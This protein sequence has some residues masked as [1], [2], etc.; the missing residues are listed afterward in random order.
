M[1]NP[2]RP[3]FY[4][5]LYIVILYLR[6]QEYVPALLNLPIVPIS[7]L[8]ATFFWFVGQKKDFQA[9]Q[10]TLLLWLTIGMSISVVRSDGIKSA[11]TVIYDFIPTLLLF[12]IVATSVDGVKRFKQLSWVLMLIS[13]VI[14]MH[15]IGQAGDEEGLGWTGAKMIEGR[16]T[17]LG[18]LNDP[19][20]L[21]MAFLMSLPFLFYLAHQSSSFFIRMGCYGITGTMLYAIYLC[22][23][24]GSILSLLAMAS[25]YAIRRFGWLR[26]ALVGPLLSVPI[27]LFAPSRMSDVSADEESAAGRVDAWFEGF[28]MFKN[29]PIFG[30]GKGLFVDHNELT[31]HN[32][33][34]LAIAELGLFGYFFWISVLFI[35]GLML[36]RILNTPAP[37]EPAVISPKKPTTPLAWAD[38]QLMSATLMYALIGSLVAAFFLSRSY[39]VFLYLLVGLI[40]AMYQLARQHWPQFTEIRARSMLGKLLGV[41]IG[42]IVLLW[43]IT[44]IL[45]KMS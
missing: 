31:A 27:L 22:N 39:V 18:F 37:G 41:E 25:T 29:Y 43:L 19:N 20:D 10:H 6:P 38:L 21:S 7:L 17:Y 8:W 2:L 33:F 13:L 42:S 1:L 45:L 23:S 12:Y 32:S 30:V 14:S 15:G 36:Y 44:R 16:S 28:D 26:S 24:R 35:S 11:G 4:L 34:I 9:P 3:F 40:V 5:L